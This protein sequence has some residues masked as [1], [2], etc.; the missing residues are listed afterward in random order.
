MDGSIIT[1]SI[2]GL[3]SSGSCVSSRVISGCIWNLCL[4][5]VKSVT[6]DFGAEIKSELSS[7]GC[8]PL[9]GKC[10]SWTPAV[11]SLVQ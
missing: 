3:C 8:L 4:S 6:V 11:E 5:V 1:P 9:S 10:S 7:G 2:L